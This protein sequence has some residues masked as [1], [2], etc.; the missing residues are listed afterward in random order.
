[1][2]EGHQRY[3]ATRDLQRERNWAAY[4]RQQA[5]LDDRERGRQWEYTDRASEREAKYTDRS[6]E[7]AYYYGDRSEE[8][9]HQKEMLC[10][11]RG[12]PLSTLSPAAPACPP[13]PPIP[14]ELGGKSTT[15]TR[16]ETFEAAK[17]DFQKRYGERFKNYFATQ[18]AEWPSWIPR[19]CD[20]DGTTVRVIYSS[21]HAEFG[22]LVGEQW[23]AYDLWR[24]EKG[25]IEEMRKDGYSCPWPE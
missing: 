1:M 21:Q 24:D 25:V 6:E 20:L 9:T 3:Y 5:Q 10:L 7:R 15:A 19:E 11:Q 2:A 23:L 22:V 14:A 16:F 18:P 13:A 8:R 4:W 17:A 12:I